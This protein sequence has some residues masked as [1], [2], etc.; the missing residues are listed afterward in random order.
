MFSY[1]VVGHE[2]VKLSQHGVSRMHIFHLIQPVST[3]KCIFM[4][5]DQIEPSN[6][7]YNSVYDEYALNARVVSAASNRRSTELHPQKAS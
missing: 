7:V 2:A 5:T 1:V 4:Y 3:C 6:R